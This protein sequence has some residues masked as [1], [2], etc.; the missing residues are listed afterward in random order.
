MT[1]NK[2]REKSMADQAEQVEVIIVGAGLS[3]L[4]AALTLQKSGKQ[5]IVLEAQPRVG[6][7]VLTSYSSENMIEYG[8]QFVSPHQPRIQKLLLEYGLTTTSTYNKGKTLYAFDDQKKRSHID[9]PFS[10]STLWD[11]FRVQHLLK[12]LLHKID[13]KRPWDTDNAEVLDSVTWQSWL[14]NV[15]QSKK[16]KTFFRV[17][18]EVGLCVNPAEI[19][20][21]DLIW[22]LKSTGSLKCML[23]AEEEWIT[24][25]ASKLPERMAESLKSCIRLNESVQRINW[26]MSNVQ[27]ST[28]NRTWIGKKVIM[29]IPP[30]FT[31]RIISEPRL[32]VN[33]E[34]ISKCTGQGDAIKCILVYNE[35]FWRRDRKNGTSF[36]DRGPVK[37]TIDISP[38]WQHKGV[39]AAFIIGKEARRL[40]K[41]PPHL[42]KVEILKCLG[43][44]MGDLALNPTDYFEKDWSKDPWAMGGYGAHLAPGLLTSSGEAILKP[45]GPIHWAGTE[46]A[47][48]WRLFM[49]GALEA[50]ERAAFE[51]MDSLKD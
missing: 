16:A 39:L 7:R 31:S 5:I 4:M 15:I 11:Y 42:R 35:P 46:T 45:I 29:A 32:P 28:Q 10:I 33:R 20:V 2:G 23:T 17:M 34:Q 50:G 26:S 18:S 51:V 30:I 27:I 1:S 48:E 9:F 38:P 47:I 3:G 36:Y 25:G 21:L 49:E 6:G 13:T 43:Y 22:D 44:L 41:M 14:D 24:E 8:A 40:G 12:K 37:Q 19:S